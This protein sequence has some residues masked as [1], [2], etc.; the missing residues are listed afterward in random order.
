[1]VLRYGLTYSLRGFKNVPVQL[2]RDKRIIQSKE[3]SPLCY[4]RS[5]SHH[6]KGGE[7][8][9]VTRGERILCNYYLISK[10]N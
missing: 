5:A 8:G 6:K 10:T 2:P 7:I 9:P 1:M 3:V 4:H